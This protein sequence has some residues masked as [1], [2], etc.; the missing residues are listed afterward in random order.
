MVKP[1]ETIHMS[2]SL[3][4]TWISNATGATRRVPP[5]K[6]ELPTLPEHLNSPLAFSGV[7]VARPFI[8][9][10]VFCR[11][12]SVF[13]SFCWPLCCQS[14]FDLRIMITSL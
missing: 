4:S 6:E 11:M 12:L 14:F 1:V 10:V 13:L 3:A 5:I 2:L 8:F 7:R 9:C